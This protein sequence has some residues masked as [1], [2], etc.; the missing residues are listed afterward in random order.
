MKFSA[1]WKFLHKL[2]F[3]YSSGIINGVLGI[4]LIKYLVQ[5]V[6]FAGYGVYSVYLISQ[7]YLLLFDSSVTRSLVRSIIDDG[8]NRSIFRSHA[9]AFWIIGIA[10]IIGI[11]GIGAW[12]FSLPEDARGLTV[13]FV[14]IVSVIEFLGNILISLRQSY[15]VAREDFRSIS[16]FT[17]LSGLIRYSLLF[18]SIYLGATIEQA[19]LLMLVKKIIEIAIAYMIYDAPFNPITIN[20]DIKGG[21][22]VLIQ[23]IPISLA[24]I[25]Q[26]GII[27]LPAI[28]I[29]RS[30]G[31]EGLGVFRS[32]F[33][34]ASRIWFI[35]NGLG[36]IVFPLFAKLKSRVDERLLVKLAIAN[37]LSLLCYVILLSMIVIS[38]DLILGYLDLTE[39]YILAVVIIFMGM[40]LNAH[41]NIMYELMQSFGKPLYVFYASIISVVPYL[42]AFSDDATLRAS[43]YWVGSQIIFLLVI[44]IFYVKLLGSSRAN[45]L[46]VCSTILAIIIM[47]LIARY[48]EFDPTFYAL[49]AV[50]SALSLIAFALFRRHASTGGREV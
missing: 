2:F 45:I 13:I 9:S 35:S 40:F 41:S 47:A 28:A 22:T 48:K 42:F 44:D 20:L 15:V 7:S 3:V 11:L 36:L 23:S 21:R 49:I 27:S 10:L 19:V 18:L 17:I 12:Q 37:G 25:S 1:V 29:G 50:V 5:K 24:Q 31:I 38:V 16:I 39:N 32:I 30:M 34:L 14:I 33:D 43:F 26:T 6:G 46:K 4:L 8:E